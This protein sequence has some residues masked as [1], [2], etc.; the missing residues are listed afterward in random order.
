MDMAFIE[1][2]AYQRAVRR[3][4]RLT[5]QEELAWY[6]AYVWYSKRVRTLNYPF[7]ASNPISLLNV[8]TH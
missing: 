6:D 1:E 7:L 8:V 3:D 4:N 2:S 5:P